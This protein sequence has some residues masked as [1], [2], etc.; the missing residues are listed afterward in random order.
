MKRITLFSIILFFIN[1][2]SCTEDEMSPANLEKDTTTL[3]EEISIERKSFNNLLTDDDFKESL[4][5]FNLIL[6]VQKK[7]IHLENLL[8]FMILQ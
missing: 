7:S 3:Q 8:V 6:K 1:F 2:F 4:K 5:S